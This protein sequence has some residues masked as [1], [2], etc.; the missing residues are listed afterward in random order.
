MTE[1]WLEVGFSIL[2]LSGLAMLIYGIRM[3]PRS[4]AEAAGEEQILLNFSGQPEESPAVF[5][6]E[7]NRETPSRGVK[8]AFDP[9]KHQPE[10][11]G[12]PKKD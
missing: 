4:S 6:L 3:K 7:M 9:E 11:I 8:T 2:A 1:F 12:M 10:T 5:D